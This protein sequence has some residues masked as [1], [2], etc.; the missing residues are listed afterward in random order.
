MGLSVFV[1]FYGCFQLLPQAKRQKHQ[2]RKLAA[3]KKKSL[4]AEHRFFSS[5]PIEYVFQGPIAICLESVK[6]YSAH[7]YDVNDGWMYIDEAF[8]HI[9]VLRNRYV[10]LKLVIF[11][12]HIY[13]FF[14]FK[15]AM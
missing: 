5:S 7:L 10:R 4:F 11:Y 12:K 3:G 14:F 9:P 15:H 8:G 6:A 1:C 13:V 2:F